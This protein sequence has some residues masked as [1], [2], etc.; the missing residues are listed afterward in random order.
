MAHSWWE[1]F[2]LFCWMVGAGGIPTIAVA[3]LGR[4]RAQNTVAAPAPAQPASVPV[5]VTT[6]WLVQNLLEI[7]MTVEAIQKNQD[8]I[9]VSVSAMSIQVNALTA[10]LR[11]RRPSK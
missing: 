6:P 8:A 1:G 11:T 7:K 10:K 3:F 2:Q 5:E 9:V 4:K